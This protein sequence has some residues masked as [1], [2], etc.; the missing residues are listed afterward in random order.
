MY[1]HHDARRQGST[2]T[3]EQRATLAEFI[4][5]QAEPQPA[6]RAGEAERS[7]P[8]AAERIWLVLAAHLRGLEATGVVD[9]RSTAAI[10][11]GLD[12]AARPGVDGQRLRA[13]AGDLAERVDA[14]LSAEL[15]GAVT[16]GI[17]WED[18]TATA[19][20]I[21]LRDAA[22]AGLD[23]A[24]R[25]QGALLAM[26]DL[27]PV[28]LMQGFHTGRPV[29][30]VTFAHL[31]GGTIGPVGEGIGRA[32]AAF[33]RLNRGPL[34]AG[35]MSGEVVGAERAEIAG[36]LG[37]DAAIPNTFDAVANVEDIVAILDAGAAL[38]APVARLLDELL[39]LVRTDPLALVFADEWMRDDGQ[40]PGFSAA[41]GVVLLAGDLRGAAI[42]AVALVT[43]LRTLPY[44]PLGA[45]LD[46]I[47]RD[48]RAS[49]DRHAELFGR[50]ERLFRE[51]LTVNRAYLAN[52][53]GRDYTTSNDL[54]AFLMTEEHLPPS[55]A[56]NIASLTMRRMRDENVAMSAIS[57]EMVDTAAMLVIGRELKVE[58]ET[59]GRWFAPRR[60]L[61]RRLVEGSPAPA[62]TREWLEDEEGRNRSSSDAITARAARV[63]AAEV[64]IRRWIDDRATADED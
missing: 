18:W 34:G 41:E 35:S 56:R 27:H 58:M 2:M 50:V 62:K 4:G 21:G 33:D 57:P 16:L 13:L 30:P 64:A 36:W 7:D 61:E 24:A 15:A 60:F 44:G 48:V 37:F 54:A 49:L 38:A 39:T 55:V 29:Q 63:R 1:R 46:W 11:G 9:E 6:R 3:D 10:A 22:I 25:M 31:L 20:R 32:L 23:A 45:M 42:D 40:L 5:R 47:D 19:V 12:R 26:A 59:L 53:A 51:A 8:D 17:A 14:G 52:R 43:R 28:S